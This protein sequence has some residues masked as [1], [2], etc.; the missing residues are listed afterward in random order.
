MAMDRT[1]SERRDRD[2]RSS[3]QGKDHAEAAAEA[4]VQ[5]ALREMELDS[6]ELKALPGNDWRKV[7]IAARLQEN[8]TV[9]QSW[10]AT[11]LSMRSAGNVSQQLFRRKR[12]ADGKC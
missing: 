7:E 6:R 4:I 12:G 5:G 11:R 9:S 3:Q 1:V 10:I 8:T 2:F